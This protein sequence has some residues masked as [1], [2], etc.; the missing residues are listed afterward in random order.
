MYGEDNATMAGL[1][2]DHLL[3]TAIAVKLI[4]PVIFVLSNSFTK[5]KGSFY[6]NSTLTEKWGDYIAQDVVGYVDKHF[7]TIPDKNSRGVAG[8][9]MGGNG[10]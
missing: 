6:T 8:A 4:K 2:I 7:K 10:A 3:D 9:S 5:Y 1:G